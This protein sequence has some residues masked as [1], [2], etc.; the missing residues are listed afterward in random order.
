MKRIDH[1]I[2]LGHP[3]RKLRKTVKGVSSVSMQRSETL[4][5]PLTVLE[6]RAIFALVVE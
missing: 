4:A 6:Q 5:L 3:Q 1:S 2:N